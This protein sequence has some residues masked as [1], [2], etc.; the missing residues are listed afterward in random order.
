MQRIPSRIPKGS[1]RRQQVS[2]GIK[3][4]AGFP[5]AVDAENHFPPEMGVQSGTVR[6]S[7]VAQRP[8][9]DEP[10]RGRIL[11]S[12]PADPELEGQ[13]LKSWTCPDFIRIPV[14]CSPPQKRVVLGTNPPRFL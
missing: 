9:S 11:N 7:G 10:T 13:G 2:A 1:R 6:R 14:I 4:A 8:L 3:I 5:D 12:H